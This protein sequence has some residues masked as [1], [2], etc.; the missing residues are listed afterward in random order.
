MT[1]KRFI[2]LLILSFL[3]ASCCIGQIILPK[4]DTVDIY[5][6]KNG[7]SFRNYMH[8]WFWGFGI[9]NTWGWDP[10]KSNRQDS[11]VLIDHP[12]RYFKVYDKRHRLMFEGLS[13]VSSGEM[14]GDIKYYYKH[15]QLKRIE[16]W[17]QP[18]PDTICANAIIAL[19]DGINPEGT[20]K[21]FRKDGTLKKQV[22]YIIKVKYC[23]PLSYRI[24][25]QTSKFKKNRK[26]KSIRQKTIHIFEL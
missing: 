14:E 18:G 22:N 15:G 12:P 9:R 6:N 17:A 24:I 25:R 20:W 5:K 23:E 2:L 11:L 8:T 1:R 19:S 3:S 21:Y 4:V 16:H 13:G 26:I 7:V 10:S